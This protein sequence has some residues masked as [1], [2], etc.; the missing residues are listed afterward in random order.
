M[1]SAIVCNRELSFAYGENPTF[2][3]MALRPILVERAAAVCG[4]PLHLAVVPVGLERV[5]EQG[6]RRVAAH[7][8]GVVG[9]HE[10]ASP[11]E[12]GRAAHDDLR[13]APVD[14]DRLVVLEAAHV[15]ALDVGPAGRGDET[16]LRLRLTRVRLSVGPVVV[17]DHPQPAAELFEPRDD[18][19]FAQVIGHDAHLGALVRDR[20]VQHLEDGVARLEAHPLEGFL[21]GWMSRLEL[22]AV[23]RLCGQE[24]R[25]RA[26]ALVPVH[27]RL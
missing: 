22:E 27:E 7:D 11:A 16:V 6:N 3:L 26:P 10:E 1:S 15:L 9:L 24:R 12:V 5:A 25:D 14:D 18:V 21:C 20:L 23:V 8:D 13:P 4:E 2:A 19:R 17:D